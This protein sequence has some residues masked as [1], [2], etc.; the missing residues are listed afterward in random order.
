VVAILSP[1]AIIALGFMVASLCKRSLD[2]GVAWL[3]PMITYWLS[4]ALVIA[5]LRSFSA[6]RT[7][8]Q[9]SKGSWGWRASL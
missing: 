8:L 1:F 4:L 6:Y 5:W 7:W 9:P 2:P 3:P